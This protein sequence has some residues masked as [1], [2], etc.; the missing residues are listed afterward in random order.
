LAAFETESEHRRDLERR[1]Q[2]HEH[3]VMFW[4]GVKEL[5]GMIMAFILF[6]GAIYLGFELLMNDKE[7]TGLVSFLGALGVL[8]GIV[9]FRRHGQT[10]TE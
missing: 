7:I 4:D 2:R 10:E 6:G 5:L 3:R 1:E 8:G 9:A